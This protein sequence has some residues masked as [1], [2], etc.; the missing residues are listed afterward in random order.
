MREM[1]LN[2]AEMSPTSPEPDH[3]MTTGG[4]PFYDR[5]P[6]FRLVGRAF[7]YLSNLFYPVGLVHR[8]AIVGE[9]GDVKGYMRIAVQ[10]VNENDEVPTGIKQSGTAKVVF[11]DD[12]YFR[13][14]GCGSVI[15]LWMAI[16][17]SVCSGFVCAV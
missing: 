5:F 4:D 2:E 10:E 3:C 9:R 14:V 16:S 13:K 12:D 11:N 1:Y 6:W 17:L 8:A 15:S 7:V